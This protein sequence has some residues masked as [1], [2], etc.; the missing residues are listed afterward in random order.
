VGEDGCEGV[1]DITK[2]FPKSPKQKPE[3]TFFLNMSLF[4]LR[5][6][7][8]KIH[9]IICAKNLIFFSNINQCYVAEAT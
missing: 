5:Y 9:A 7:K 8:N 3:K 2:E 6:E 4:F 1:K